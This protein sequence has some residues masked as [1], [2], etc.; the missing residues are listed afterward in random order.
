MYIPKTPARATLHQAIAISPPGGRCAAVPS[1]ERWSVV[2]DI[3]GSCSSISTVR[4]RVFVDGRCT[5]GCRA[6]RRGDA[7]AEEAEHGVDWCRRSAD[8]RLENT[9]QRITQEFLGNDASV[10]VESPLSLPR[11]SV[12]ARTFNPIALSVLRLL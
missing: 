11:C 1:G 10:T 2:D 5:C 7:G 3:S 9:L 6:T 12:R 8:R 4:G